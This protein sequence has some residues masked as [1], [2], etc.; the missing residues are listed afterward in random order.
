VTKNF[1]EEIA[2]P[3]LAL[4]AITLASVEAE[5]ASLDA[6][7]KAVRAW[8]PATWPPEHWKPAVPAFLRQPFA[9]DPADVGWH[10]YIALRE[11]DGKRTLIG[12]VGGLR[13]AERPGECE[14]GYSVVEEYRERGYATE[15]AQA[16]MRWALGREGVVE[17]TA[18]T[19]PDLP[20]SIRVMEKCG[21]AYTGPGYEEGTVLYRRPR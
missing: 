21:L 4:L 12:T 11:E 20:K 7:A 19:F 6:L 17:I 13:R 2:T 9:A 5:R 10:R 16:M 18:Q 3:R 1:V 8:V 15:A 14:I